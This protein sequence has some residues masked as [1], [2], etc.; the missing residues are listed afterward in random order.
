MIIIYLNEIGFNMR[1]NKR[2]REVPPLDENSNRWNT[3]LSAAT[4]DELLN[5]AYNPDN[6]YLD[7]GLKAKAA[8]L[9]G[10][11]HPGLE[12]HRAIMDY[13][14][15][16]E[17][18]TPPTV[19]EMRDEAIANGQTPNENDDVVA[20][21]NGLRNSIPT[22]VSADTTT[23][24]INQAI[25]NEASGAFALK[26]VL[27]DTARQQELDRIENARTHLNYLN[28]LADSLGVI[29]GLYGLTR[30]GAS[31]LGKISTKFSNLANKM[32]K[33]QIYSSSVG[34]GT[35]IYNIISG[36][37][38]NIPLDAGGATLDMFGVLGG[39]NLF[40]RFGNY[41]KVADD[42][43]DFLGASGNTADIVQGTSRLTR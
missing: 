32:D 29:S 37:S 24:K 30:Y 41:G 43:F 11:K 34:G 13:R 33:G 16:Y 38:D 5:I 40:R 2:L 12:G 15:Q 3:D 8:S 39:T 10:D 35:N 23:N 28:Y 1:R 27:E 4:D 31:K 42:L 21:M 26:K 25:D 9:F 6:A 7:Q 14:R 22:S 19:K 18:L 36:N 20:I 17:D